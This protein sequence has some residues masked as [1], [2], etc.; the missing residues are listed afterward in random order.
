MTWETLVV[1]LR[2]G[3]IS[4]EVYRAAI[5]DL[6]RQIHFKGCQGEG[7]GTILRWRGDLVDVKITHTTHSLLTLGQ[8]LTIPVHRLYPVEDSLWCNFR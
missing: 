4:L 5:R 2:T 3:V 7:V 1:D 8:E 6:F